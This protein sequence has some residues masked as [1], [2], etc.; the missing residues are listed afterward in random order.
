MAI[1]S[2]PPGRKRRRKDKLHSPSLSTDY[3]SGMI[4]SRV[5]FTVR[6]QASLILLILICSVSV[7][8]QPTD[9]SGRLDTLLGDPALGA[10]VWAVKV[11]SVNNGEVLYERN[12]RVLLVPASNLKLVTAIA[13][14]QKL[15]LDYR[16]RTRIETDGEIRNGVLE[17]SLIIRGSGDPTLGARPSSP[18]LEHMEAGNPWETFDSWAQHLKSL[19]IH[20]IRGDLVGDDTLLAPADPGPGWAWDD[21][22]WGYASPAGGLLFN[23]N[24]VL[25]HIVSSGPGSVPRLEIVP[26]L[27]FLR[28]VSTMATACEGQ[29][30]EIEL[31][32]DIGENLTTIGGIVRPSADQWRS[33]NAGDPSRYFMSALRQA[34]NR[35]GIELEG[36][37][38]LAGSKP[39]SAARLLFTHDSPDLR[40]ILRVL[41]KT[42]H[43]L[44]AEVLA[45]IIST[46]PSRKSLESGIEQIEEVL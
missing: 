7:A 40:Y 10:S 1:R 26:D 34:L 4:P 30:P 14:I 19:G 33:V 41:L 32:R 20:A 36:T 24:L 9:L 15:G 13:A 39:P 3:N 8:G 22:P 17:G 45:R 28:I 37:V 21:L 5:R 43:N 6:R 42:S 31:T 11:V 44:Y 27:P 16:F 25:L 2:T 38:R 46:Q 23:E 29:L 12:S 35:A 18:D